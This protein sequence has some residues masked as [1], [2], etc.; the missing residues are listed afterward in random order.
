MS[1]QTS[2]YG[3]AYVAAHKELRDLLETQQRTE[4]RLLVVR[5]SIQTL[6]ELCESEGISVEPSEEAADLIEQSTLSDEI[7]NILRANA[8][9]RYRP[10]QVKNELVKLG[11]DLSPYQNSQATIHMILKRMVTSKEV[12]EEIAPIDQKQTYQWISRFPRL[13]RNGNGSIANIPK[14]RE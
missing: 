13:Q 2:N 4:K 8:G 3:R 10:H 14:M 1:K 9:A 12:K 6:R 11:H 5:K 7:R